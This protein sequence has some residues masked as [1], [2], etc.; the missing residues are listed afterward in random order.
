MT[1]N[2]TTEQAHT[3]PVLD[4]DESDQRRFQHSASE[5]GVEIHGG[6][7]EVRETALCNQFDTPL[8]TVDCRQADTDD[9]VIDAAARQLG[10]DEDKIDRLC[11]TSHD[12]ARLLEE[13]ESNLALLE[14]DALDFKDQRSVAR[15]MKAVA[16]GIETNDIML[17]Y[18]TSKQEA[19]V[20][21]EPDLSM[22][23]QSF[24]AGQNTDEYGPLSDFSVGDTIEISA[25][26]TPMEVES[27]ETTVFGK[28]LI[29]TNHHGTYHLQSRKHDQ[30]DLEASQ[31]LIRDVEVSHA[32]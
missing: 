13:T 5:Y 11:M 8:A 14:F 32:E 22:R 28:K 16:E 29:A 1:G 9:A 3:E 20:S 27:V 15:S 31:G 18:T 6:T 4:L 19:V 25:R 30:V 21:A 2:P 12:I 24:R 23:V 7:P 26:E 17:G 10:V